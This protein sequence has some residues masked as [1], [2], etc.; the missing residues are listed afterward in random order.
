M[1]STGSLPL[2]SIPH[3]DNKTQTLYPLSTWGLK[4]NKI[5]F[6]FHRN[7][8]PKWFALNVNKQDISWSGVRMRRTRK[9]LGMI[10]GSNP[11]ELGELLMRFSVQGWGSEKSRAGKLIIKPGVWRPS[12]Q[13]LWHLRTGKQTPTPQKEREQINS[14]C[15][16]VS[17]YALHSLDDVSHGWQS[18]LSG[19]WP[20]CLPPLKASL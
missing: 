14:S 8:G 4:L 9:T 1:I 19:C 3:S 17:R 20:K 6:Q 11:W 18:P 7:K 10:W 13:S 16:F 5:L 15:T 2:L 12:Y